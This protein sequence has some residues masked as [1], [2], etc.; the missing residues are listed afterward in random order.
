MKENNLHA[1]LLKRKIIESD[2]E[3]IKS[4]AEAT[5]QLCED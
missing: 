1:D 5:L 3:K 4:R 2:E